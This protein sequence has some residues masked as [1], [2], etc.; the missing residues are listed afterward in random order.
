M[1]DRI[2]HL[3]ITLDQDYRDD[4]VAP[5]VEAIRMIRGVDHVEERVVEGTEHLARMAVRAEVRRE[6][7]QAIEDVFTTKDEKKP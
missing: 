7:H 6:I 4:D 5:I 2:R 3:T 1:T